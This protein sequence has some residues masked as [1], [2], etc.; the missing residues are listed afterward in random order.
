MKTMKPRTKRFLAGAIV[1]VCI[2][3]GFVALHIFMGYGVTFY[4]SFD[5]IQSGMSETQV[6]AAL[7]AADERSAEFRLGQ[8]E[9]FEKEYARA[10]GSGSSYYLLWNKGIDVVYAIGFDRNG[11]VTMKAIGGT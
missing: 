2:A 10:A 5:R 6:V 8:Y 9:G 4:G 3:V 7:G 11:R 1:V